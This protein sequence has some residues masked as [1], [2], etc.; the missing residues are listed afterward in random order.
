MAA[1]EIYRN[2]E[3]RYCEFAID[4]ES[5]LE[6]LPT[7][8]KSG[9]GSMSLSSPCRQGSTAKAADG[10]VYTLSGNNQ[11]TYSYKS[12]G[13]G[14]GSTYDEDEQ[15]A[16]IIEKTKPSTF[17]SAESAIEQLNSG[18]VQNVYLGQTVIINK[19][20]KYLLYSIQN[21]ED[22]YTVEPVDTYGDVWS[23]DDD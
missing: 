18:Q 19:N 2:Y 12:N 23:D 10:K 15:I 3:T 11:W 20:G 5:D 14:S 9:S 13:S 1:Y 7:F 22:G 17:D 8:Q 21:G 6:T 4:D 16:K